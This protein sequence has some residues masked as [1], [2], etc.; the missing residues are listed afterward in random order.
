MIIILFIYYRGMFFDGSSY[1]YIE[2]VE[3]DS[4]D[5]YHVLYKHEDLKT[6]HTCGNL[7]SNLVLYFV[8]KI[9]F[10]YRIS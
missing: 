9:F 6:N 10:S 3:H 5:K 7:M 1:H 8:C 2:N 4:G